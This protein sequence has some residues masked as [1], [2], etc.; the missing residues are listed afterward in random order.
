MKYQIYGA[1][2]YCRAII[3]SQIIKPDLVID[4]LLDSG[5]I[6]GVEVVNIKDKK[7]DKNK[8][9]YISIVGYEN[10]SKQLHEIGFTDVREVEDSFITF[11]NSLAALNSD[12]EFW[13]SPNTNEK[14]DYSKIEK[15]KK[16]LSD[17]KSKITLN[18]IVRYREQPSAST[19]PWPERYDM[20]FPEDIPNLYSEK[21]LNIIDCGAFDGDTARI[22]LSRYGDK[23]GNYLAIEPNPE[24]ISML[25][26]S[27]TDSRVIPIRV[28]L[29]NKNGYAFISNCSSAS[30]ISEEKKTNYNV[31][32]KRLDDIIKQ[33]KTIPNI[34]KLDIEGYE[35][36][37]LL[38]I[39]EIIK[40][41]T[42]TLILSIYHTPCDLWQIALDV[43][44][45][46]PD[47]YYFYIRN[48]GYW[49]Y[50]TILYCIAK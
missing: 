50:E 43:E 31:E 49:G 37:V 24:N 26:K 21:I 1:G 23:I 5:E 28:A 22:F 36:L 6:E 35:R 16:I 19:Y 34:I 7:I 20:Y 47:S 4:G 32:T 40:N 44:S 18:Q 29:N 14:V 3:K 39:K 27:I 10:I 42:P 33:T 15:L 41:T 46:A 17:E 30:K 11:E 13:R 9:T 25:E 2:I 38:T 12:G 45:Y 48:E 8:T